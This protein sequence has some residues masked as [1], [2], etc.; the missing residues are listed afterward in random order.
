M[1]A[2]GKRR[3]RPQLWPSLTTA[4]A[5]GILVAMG[6]WQLERL[7]WKRDLIAEMTERM[8]GPAVALPPPPVD[9]AAL[10]YRPIRLQGRFRHN[11][12]LYLE[13]RTY[14]G[15][16]GLHLVTPLVLD[17]GRVVLVDRGWVPPGRRRPETR[18]EGQ[19][20]GQVA[21]KVTLTATLRTGGWQGYAF[22]RPENDP[23]ANAWVWMDLPRMAA[24]VGLE[25]TASGYYLVAGPAPNPGGLPIGRAPGVELPNNHLGYAITWYA[26][27]FVLLVIYLLHQSRPEPEQEEGTT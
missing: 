12:E 7:E 25:G 6:S 1:T 4:I 14:K 23:A 11:R 9:A 21:G 2:T 17:D 13:A 15:R 10:R 20:G 8:A 16:A 18:P 22:L 5:F 19:I 26:L 3:F 24:S 27:A